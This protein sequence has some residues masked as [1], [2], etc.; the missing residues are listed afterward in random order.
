MTKLR[1]LLFLWKQAWSIGMA[2]KHFFF[3]SLLVMLISVCASYFFDPKVLE[4]DL[5]GVA[6][7]DGEVRSFEESKSLLCGRFIVGPSASSFFKGSETLRERS[8]SGLTMPQELDNKFFA[9]TWEFGLGLPV[10]R[11]SAYLQHIPSQNRLFQVLSGF[12][13]VKGVPNYYS[14]QFVPEQN[15]VWAVPISI[16]WSN[17]LIAVIMTTFISALSH[18]LA[19]VIVRFKRLCMHVCWRCG[20]PS[21]NSLKKCSECGSVRNF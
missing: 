21:V 1:K 11:G 17:Y 6:K 16:I 7:I 2:I 18:S 5:G 10:A 15:G 20:Y 9:V 3:A 12:V 19:L 4:S 14:D 13:V 8:S